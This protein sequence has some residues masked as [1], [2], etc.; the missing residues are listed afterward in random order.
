MDKSAFYAE[1]RHDLTGPLA[2]I[3]VIEVTT[4]WAGPMAGCVL[5]DFGA[6]VIKVEHPEGEVMRR[7]PPFVPGT[8]LSVLHEVLN[9]NKQNISLSLKDSEGR[10]MFLALCKSADIVI[11]NFKP[12][13]LAGWGVGYNDV[14]KVKPD[15]VYASISG[16]GQFGPYCARPG[17]DPIAQNFTGWSSLNGDPDGGPTKAPT[18]LGD[19][20]GGLHCALG[21]MAALLH[22]NRTGEGQHVD[23]ALVDGLIFQSNG[24]LTMGA[25][26][27]ASR[28]WGNQFAIAAPVNV[29]AC[30]DGNVYTGVLL[31]SHWQV[32]THH[33]GRP[34]LSNLKAPDRI[35]RRH[36]LDALL[37][38]WCVTRTTGEVVETMNALGLAVTRVNTFAESARDPHVQARDMLQDTELTTGTRVPLTGPAA[39]FSRTPTRV[40]SAAPALGQHTDELLAEIGV[41]AAQLDLLRAKGII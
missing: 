40:R 2:G 21:A 31:D 9:R 14:R 15:I 37:A 39:K 8:T 35:E 25:M 11:E 29:Y 3:K 24:Q 22:R 18:F 20:L 27:L 16:F 13:T 28:R 26:G 5:A 12:G 17:Y 33:I 1:A 34:E 10:D 38:G 36:E 23:I 41:T 32:F 4:T 6:T 19:D 30:T 7:V